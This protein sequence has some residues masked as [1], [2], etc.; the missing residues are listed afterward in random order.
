MLTN[1]NVQTF[2]AKMILMVFFMN[3]M[4]LQQHDGSLKTIGLQNNKELHLIYLY[5]KP[6]VL[7]C[8]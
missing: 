2:A 3:D 8:D 1:S 6:I 4:K 7:C 5:L